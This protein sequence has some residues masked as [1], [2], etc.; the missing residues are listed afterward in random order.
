MKTR[1]FA[2]LLA[3]FGTAHSFAEAPTGTFVY[4]LNPTN[5]PLWD[6]SGQLDLQQNII[7]VAAQGTPLQVPVTVDQNIKGRLAGAGFTTVL[8]D[9][10]ALNARYRVEGKVYTAASRTKVHLTVR[11]SGRDLIGGITN[12]YKIVLVYKL[13]LDAATNVLT[14]TV[15]GY[16]RFSQVKGGKINQ[17]ISIPLPAENDGSWMLTLA[18]NTAT[19]PGGNAAITLPNGRFL[20][21]AVRGRYSSSRDTTRLSLSG[22]GN[23]KGSKL[24][25]YLS[26]TNAIITDLRGRVF[27]QKLN[28]ALSTPPTP[29]PP[30][31]AE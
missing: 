14:G 5:L 28:T 6:L 31:P 19:P 1:L 2:L 18:L 12:T 8:V 7:G 17:E 9:T 24:T 3:V 26:T 16:A 11:A 27:G 29:P 21:Y 13:E 25:L 10:N 30:K 4:D 22:F 23:S 20:Q 15:R